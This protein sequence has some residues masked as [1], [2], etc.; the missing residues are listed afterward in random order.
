[1]TERRLGERQRNPTL[2]TKKGLI[3]DLMAEGAI[4]FPPYV[5]DMNFN[6][7]LIAYCF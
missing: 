3:C 7:I 6:L 1:M 5:C 4:A 2:L